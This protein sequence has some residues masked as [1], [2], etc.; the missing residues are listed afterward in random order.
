MAGVAGLPEPLDI[1]GCDTKQAEKRPSE[2]PANLKKCPTF[3]AAR[4]IR[5][6][7][8]QLST[9]KDCGNDFW[10]ER[11]LQARLYC[12]RCTTARGNRRVKAWRDRAT[13]SR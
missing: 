12:D 13:L 8:A 1:N 3:R 5:K 2:N 6:P 7:V 9:C 10:Y 11:T 4:T